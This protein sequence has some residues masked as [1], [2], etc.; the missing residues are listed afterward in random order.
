VTDLNST[1]PT[2]EDREA[3]LWRWLDG[4]T[5][6]W[7]PLDATALTATQ[8]G[9]FNR[10]VLSGQFQLRLHIVARSANPQPLIHAT[11]VVTG[12]YKQPLLRAIRGA[13]P[14]FSERVVIQTQK[15]E[16]RLSAAGLA[17]QSEMRTLGGGPT[18]ARF[19]A[20]SLQ[21]TIP[22]VANVTEV[23]DATPATPNPNPPSTGNAEPDKPLTAKAPVWPASKTD[24]Y[25]ADYCTKYRRKY[26]ALARDVLDER[27]GAEGAFKTKFGPTAIARDITTRVGTQ[28][29]RP[30]RPQDVLKT[31]TYRALI[32]PLM[33]T[34]PRKPVDW[35]QML[36]D[37]IGEDRPDI[38]DDIPLEDAES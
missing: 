21:F 7:V 8:S 25:V 19:L 24:G 33:Q 32:Q 17:T 10:L 15:V 9:A 37:R 2:P 6:Q 27:P 23:Q 36:K 35:D 3:A 1:N 14:A 5:Q 11:C 31:H 12:D 26:L 16:Y 29:Q 28:T 30:C 20:H 22:G 34:P 4:A 18:E 38:L 13:V